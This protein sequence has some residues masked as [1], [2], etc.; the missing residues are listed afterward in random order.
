MNLHLLVVLKVV[1]AERFVRIIPFI[2]TC[3]RAVLS[4]VSKFPLLCL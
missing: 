3:Q 4:H 1:A 2:D